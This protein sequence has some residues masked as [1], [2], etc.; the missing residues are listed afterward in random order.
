MGQD[1]ERHILKGDG[2]SV[3]QFQIVG[4]VRKDQ[5]CDFLGV[6]FFVI[7][8]FDAGFQF[9]FGIIRQIQLHHR[10][11]YFGIGHPG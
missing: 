3:K 5:R 8:V 11:G 9:I 4:T 6:K 7:G 1:G 10:I 2:L